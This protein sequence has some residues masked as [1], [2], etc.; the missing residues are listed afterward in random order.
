MD[1]SQELC[2]PS[3]E[4]KHFY[5]RPVI[6]SNFNDTASSA[7]VLVK[8]NKEESSTNT[9]NNAKNRVEEM[10]QKFED[11]D[12]SFKDKLANRVR[13]KE[14]GIVIK[15]KKNQIEENSN[16]GVNENGLNIKCEINKNIEENHTNPYA[17]KTSTAEFKGQ[18]DYSDYT[19]DPENTFLEPLI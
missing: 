11:K 16:T 2:E 5:C 1:D 14:K 6:K 13:M 15:V 4:A 3:E 12:F 7:L 19:Q 18:I 17:E 9:S 10:V 8:T